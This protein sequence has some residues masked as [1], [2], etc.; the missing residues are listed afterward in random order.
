MGG[1]AHLVSRREPRPGLVRTPV[2][3]V[4]TGALDV[5]MEAQDLPGLQLCYCGPVDELEGGRGGEAHEAGK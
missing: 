5:L 2:V 4:G 1:G 3:V